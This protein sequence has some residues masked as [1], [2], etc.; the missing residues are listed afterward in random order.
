M[1]EMPTKTRNVKADL[2]Y[3]FCEHCPNVE[4][5][6]VGFYTFGGYEETARICSNAA[7]CEMAVKMALETIDKGEP[8][9]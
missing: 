9:R 8:L 4:L 7:I 1:R 3:T 6:K 2:P 5:E